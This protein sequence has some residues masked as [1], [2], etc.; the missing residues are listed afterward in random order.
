MGAGKAAVTVAACSNLGLRVHTFFLR[1]FVT[2]QLVRRNCQHGVA[3]M[4]AVTCF[5]AVVCCCESSQLLLR[6]IRW[7]GYPSVRNPNPLLR[8]L[9]DQH[10]Q[11]GISRGGMVSLTT[12][13]ICFSPF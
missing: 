8:P 9:L 6:Q 7:N 2:V 12:A 4:S 11:L 1:H 13:S 3:W 10:T 5:V